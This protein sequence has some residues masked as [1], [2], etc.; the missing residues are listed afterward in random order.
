MKLRVTHWEQLLAYIRDA[1]ECGWYYGNK[2]QFEKRH[3]DLLKWATEQT[4]IASKE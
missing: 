4:E 3:A 1:E 2:K